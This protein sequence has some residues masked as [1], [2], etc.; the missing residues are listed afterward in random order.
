[1]A[2]VVIYK[3]ISAKSILQIFKYLNV[4]YLFF[5]NKAAEYFNWGCFNIAV[6]LLT[7]TIIV[8][9]FIGILA[10]FASAYI[11][12]R[13]YFTGKMNIVEN[14]IELILTYIMRLMVKTN[15]FGKE[16][17]KILISQGIIWILLLLAYIAANVEPSYGVI[18]DAKKS[19]MLGYYEK[20]EGLSYGNGI[21]RI[22]IMK[23][24]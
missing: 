13:K 3:V 7:T 24:N 20:A 22:F 18:Y 4:Y 10:L 15:N 16:V 21:N 6:S 8:S 1:M 14:A 2:D 17:Y 12:I 11:S 5:P 9:V 19:Y 23:Y